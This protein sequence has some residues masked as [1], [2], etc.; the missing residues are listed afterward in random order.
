MCNRETLGYALF[1]LLALAVSFLG[2]I[3]AL[4]FLVPFIV[5]VVLFTAVTL[6]IANEVSSQTDQ[7]YVEDARVR[8]DVPK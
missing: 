5:A 7:H 6:L 8:D 3:A 1:G 2:S 4:V